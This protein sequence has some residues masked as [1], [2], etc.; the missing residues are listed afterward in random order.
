MQHTSSGTFPV[1]RWGPTVAGAVSALVDALTIDAGR[2]VMVFSEMGEL[3]FSNRQA[4]EWLGD[5]SALGSVG[6]DGRTRRAEFAREN[7]D[8][9]RH[10]FRTGTSTGMVHAPGGRRQ[11]VTY[12]LLP[13]PTGTE[14][15]VLGVGH[16]L[17]F[18]EG[19]VEVGVPAD[20]RPQAVA[21]IATLTERE[22]QVLRLISQGLTT[23]QV[24]ERIGRTVKTVEA[25]RAS[26]GRKLGVT[27]RVQLAHIAMQAGLTAI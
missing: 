21:M 25:H 20:Q 8:V 1:E 19:F 27:N 10:V 7:L 18:P 11:R 2:A 5:I 6:A 26:L 17:E 4:M 23:A 22:T 14:R 16:P 3:I 13:T 15:L 9:V 24:A 12:R